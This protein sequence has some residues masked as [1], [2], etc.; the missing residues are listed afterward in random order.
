MPVFEIEKDGATYQVDAPDHAT[1]ASAFGAL[2]FQAA[3]SAKELAAD[4]GAAGAFQVGLARG[5][6][7]AVKLGSM[8]DYYLGMGQ[9]K[10]A[11]SYDETLQRNQA[12]IAEMDKQYPIAGVAGN[13]TG[14]LALG[15]GLAK[16]G[17]ALTANA[18][19]AGEGRAGL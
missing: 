8:L 14:G 11:K 5:F 15:G 13:I 6:P 1:A 10:D 4:A 18:A 7:G 12:M 16:T 2:T 19:Q 9:G 17:L 3:P